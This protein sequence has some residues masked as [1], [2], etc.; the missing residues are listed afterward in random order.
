MTVDK[1]HNFSSY[2]MSPQEITTILFAVYEHIL[3]DVDNISIN[4][5]FELFCQSLLQDNSHLPE[6]TLS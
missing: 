3:Y 1:L 2:L 4:T 6:H 5:E